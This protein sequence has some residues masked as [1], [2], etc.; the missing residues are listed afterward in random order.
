MSVNKVIIMGRIGKD[1]E[2]RQTQS[3]QSVCSFSVAC[4]EKWTD[5]N[6]QKQEN[7]EWINCTAWGKTAENIARFFGKGSEIYLEGK[8]KTDTKEE[9]GSKTYYTKVVV[10]TFQFTGGSKVEGSQQNQQPT[11]YQQNTQYQPTGYQ[12]QMPV[13]DELP[14]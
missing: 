11:G 2:T 1:I 8:I 10:D 6:G 7:T 13:E 5:K 12:Q 4:S 3:G 14:F 9:N